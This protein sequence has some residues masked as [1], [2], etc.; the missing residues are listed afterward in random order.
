M[1][2]VML[3]A[4]KNQDLLYAAELIRRGELVAIPTETVYGLGANGLDENAVR[5]IFSAKGRPSDNPL[6][7]HIAKPEQMAELC[8]S[9]P[10]TAWHLADKFWPGP[11]TMVLPVKDHVPKVTT[12]GLDTLAVRCPETPA[13]REL[14]RLAGVPIAAP[15][16]NTSGK[17]STTTAA[18]VKADMDGRISAIIDGGACKVGVESTIVDLTGDTPR[19]LRPG[20]ISPEELKEILGELLIDKAVLAQISHD[21][22]VRAPGMKYKHYAPQA[23]VLIV[24]GS[25][26]VAADYIRGHWDDGCA[27]MC[28]EEELPYYEGLYALAYGKE[29]DALSLS[30]GLFATLRELDREQIRKVYARCPEGGGVA[31]AVQNRLKKAAGFREIEVQEP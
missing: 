3:S 9:I 15:S 26:K 5:K 4:D 25:S 23:E 1:N 17:P 31:Y 20:G 11:L 8:H 29:E 7:L 28:F 14:I 6:I 19:L 21:E 27:V 22:V 13:T 2:T 10:Q 24:K 30:A 12:A 18:H 16:A